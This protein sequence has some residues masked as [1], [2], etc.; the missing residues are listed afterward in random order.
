MRFLRVFLS[1]VRYQFRYG[2]YFLYVV[3]SVVYI[4]I[5]FMAPAEVRRI[6]TAF[7]ICSDPAALGFFFIGGMLLLEKGEGIHSYLSI[8]PVTS[9][10]YV[11]AKVLSLSMISTLTGMIIAAVALGGQVNYSL[12]AIGLLT[13]SIVFTLFGFTVGT[14]ARSVNHYIVISVPAGIVL[15][16]PAMLAVFGLASPIFELLPATLLLRILYSAVG[17]DVPY[18]ALMMLTGLLLWLLLAFWI[19]NKRFKIYLQRVGG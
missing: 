1:D 2:F 18:S 8:V 13:G 4:G 19:A 16:S 9:G 17:L 15:M 14:M 10:E 12:L 3:I 5:L 7:I 6:G 11:M